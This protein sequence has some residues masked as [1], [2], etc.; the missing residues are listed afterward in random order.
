M[1][2]QVLISG[3]NILKKDAEENKTGDKNRVDFSEEF[4]KHC[5]LKYSKNE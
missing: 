5:K 3:S 2:R 4:Y 1:D